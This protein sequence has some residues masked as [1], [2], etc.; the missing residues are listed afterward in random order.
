MREKII[1]PVGDVGLPSVWL[2][3]DF[4]GVSEGEGLVG[5]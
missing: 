4:A 2:D 5:N 1:Q 3:P